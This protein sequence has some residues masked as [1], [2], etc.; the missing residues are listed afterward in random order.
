MRRHR[1]AFGF[2]PQHQQ[3]TP[4]AGRAPDVPNPSFEPSFRAIEHDDVLRL[5]VQAYNQTFHLHLTPNLDL[6]HPEAVTFRDGQAEPLRPE[7]FRVFR[8]HV[9]DDRFTDQRWLADQ[10]DVVRDEFDDDDQQGVLGWAR[11]VLR[12]DLNHIDSPVFE[13]AFQ[14]RDDLYHIKATYNYK[15][16]KRTDDATLT[17]EENA[18]MVVY[19]DSDTTLVDTLDRRSE[20]NAAPTCGFDRLSSNKG[21]SPVFDIGHPATRE[22]GL[23]APRNS[24]DTSIFGTKSLTKRQTSGCPATKKTADCTYTRYYETPEKARIQ[25]IT[26]WNLA[27]AVY[28]RSFNVV[29]GLI[30]IT[31][32]DEACPSTP[33]TNLAWNQGCSDSYPIGDRLSDFSRWRATVSEDGAS[34]WHLMTSCA[35]GVEVGIAWLKQLCVTEATAQTQNG[36]TQYV[37]GTGV[38]SIIRD[39]WK[40]VA[41]EIG[42][43]FGAIHDCTSQNCPCSGSS[44][45]CCPLSATQCDAGGTYIMNPTSNV[46]SQDF[47]PC[48]IST[49][50]GLYP[51]LGT[52][53]EDPG[54]RTVKTLSMCGN[55]IKEDGEDCDTGGVDTACCNPTTCRFKANAVCE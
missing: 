32:M 8:G 26:D 9:V 48:S 51:S 34:L 42:H 12:Q 44:C 21:P 55:G 14:T 30:N 19:R 20:T 24:F 7:Q 4:T 17:N 23:Y 15:L 2:R 45:Q 41:H 16:S 18:H 25:I 46:S 13:G 39:E 49:V 38:S 29:L 47:S 43:G 3:S 10:A 28:E 40:V 50:C 6:F 11:V 22:M 37:S 53:L 35:T 33:A 54:S 31:I 27:S 5:V 36:V 1:A 52:C